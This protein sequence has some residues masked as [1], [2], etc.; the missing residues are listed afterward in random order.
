MHVLVNIAEYVEIVFLLLEIIVAE[1]RNEVILNITSTDHIHQ[2]QSIFIFDTLILA[3]V[4]G[5]VLFQSVIHEFTELAVDFEAFLHFCEL[6]KMALLLL[7]NE[8]YPTVFQ[9]E[10]QIFDLVFH[11]LFHVLFKIFYYSLA[12]QKTDFYKTT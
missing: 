5:L 9:S 2:P 11:L 12:N 1:M 7:I 3:D 8:T 4:L 10:W 6:L